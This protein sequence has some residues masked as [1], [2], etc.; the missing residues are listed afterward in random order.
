MGVNT[1]NNRGLASDR[2]RGL[3]WR[4]AQTHLGES[5]WE[6]MLEDNR[7]SMCE[8]GLGCPR[9]RLIDAQGNVQLKYGDKTLV[10]CGQEIRRLSTQN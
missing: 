1:N 6:M 9:Y 8:G 10:A 5:E 7:L 3:D 2:S 4:E